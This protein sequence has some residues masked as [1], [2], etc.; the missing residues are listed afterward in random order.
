VQALGGT[1]RNEAAC[2]LCHGGVCN[3]ARYRRH[4]GLPSAVVAHNPRNGGT[5]ALRITD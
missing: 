3:L 1:R 5:L 4:A 2:D